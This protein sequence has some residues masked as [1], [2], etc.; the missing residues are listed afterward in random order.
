MNFK[1]GIKNK[2]LKLVWNCGLNMQ[3]IIKEEE[4]EG[5]IKIIRFVI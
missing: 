2:D 5:W 4:E 1:V 3:V